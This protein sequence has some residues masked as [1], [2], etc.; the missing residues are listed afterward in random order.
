MM[1]SSEQKA[2]SSENKGNEIMIRRI[3]FCLLLTVLLFTVSPAEAQQPRKIPRIGMFLPRVPGA[4]ALSPTRFPTSDCGRL[5]YVDGQNIVIEL[6]I[7][8]SRSR[9]GSGRSLPM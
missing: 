4:W 2:V 9:S 3:S 6:R 1:V 7:R 8:L 5:G